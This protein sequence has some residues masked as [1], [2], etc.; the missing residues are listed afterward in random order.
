MLSSGYESCVPSFPVSFVGWSDTAPLPAKGTT[1]CTPEIEG[2]GCGD[3]SP[4]DLLDGECRPVSTADTKYTI[5]TG[6]NRA[7]SR[8]FNLPSLRPKPNNAAGEAQGAQNRGVILDL[9]HFGVDYLR[10]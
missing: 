8:S 9:D 3:R 7:F 5:L 4:L 2:G 6:R 10:R 1:R